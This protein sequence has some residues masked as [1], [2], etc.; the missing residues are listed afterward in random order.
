MATITSLSM[1]NGRNLSPSPFTWPL[2]HILFCMCTFSSAGHLVLHSS[3]I[4]AAVH[5]HS[6]H[7]RGAYLNL[8]IGT[9]CT[10]NIDPNSR[11][12]YMHLLVT[13]MR[14]RSFHLTCRSA[15]QHTPHQGM[16]TAG[17]VKS[18][19]GLPLLCMLPTIHNLHSISISYPAPPCCVAQH[20]HGRWPLRV[21]VVP[22]AVVPPAVSVPRHHPCG[23]AAQREE[24]GSL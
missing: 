9:Y 7:H 15:M 19:H 20:S 2:T 24:R 12:H 10:P 11:L 17:G 1:C 8:E 14:I 3:A 4:T 13:L 18:V 23:H 16:T 6:L 21:T 5:C 22:P